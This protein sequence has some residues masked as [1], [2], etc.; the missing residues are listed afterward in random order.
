MPNN[1]RLKPETIEALRA[2]RVR[3]FVSFDF[4][5]FPM[6][7][8][9]GNVQMEFDGHQWQGIGEV[10]KE[11]FIW[12]R[13]AI[14]ASKPY[15]ADFFMASLPFGKETNEVV[16]KGYYHGRQ[17]ELFLCAF[18]EKDN[19]IEPVVYFDGV[20][21]E[22]SI[23][24]N[25]FT[26]RCEDDGLMDIAERDARHKDN[27]EPAR[28]QFKWDVSDTKSSWIGW[29]INASTLNVLGLALDCLLFFLPARQRSLK[30]RLVARKQVY[31]FKTEP[32]IPGLRLR[33]KGYNFR[34]DTTDEAN[35]MLCRKA[36]KRAWEFDRGFVRLL[37]YPDRGPP[38]M[39][40]IDHIR[41]I[42]DSERWRRT[43][44]VR[45]WLDN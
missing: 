44:P 37:V 27:V 5:F 22:C 13:S 34:A 31:W 9:D 45:Q 20:I 16:S 21:I 42:D 8:H 15:E 12:R 2:E 23:R 39:F 1:K 41:E 17:M 29:A 43:D 26:F 10:L 7:V 18:D 19:V 3:C 11:N 32:P 40:N 35:M 24:G 38:W 33:K 25:V 6:R 14:S 28:Q 30:Q 4:A 36:A